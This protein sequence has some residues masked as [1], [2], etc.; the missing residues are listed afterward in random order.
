MPKRRR[1]EAGAVSAIIEV[2]PRRGKK[3]SPVLEFPQCRKLPLDLIRRKKVIR[4]QPLDILPL[5]EAK[6]IVA[7]GRRTL[8]VMRYACNPRLRLA[9]YYWG[10]SAA[11]H[12]PFSRAHYQHLRAR[13]HSHARAVR[14]IVDR[15]LRVL[16]AMLTAGTLYDPTRRGP[17]TDAA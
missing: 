4:I 16:M 5:A 2:G 1:D 15:L 9:A 17:V 10:Q 12:D 11:R 7:S 13:G 14:G 3:Y 8:V 6:A